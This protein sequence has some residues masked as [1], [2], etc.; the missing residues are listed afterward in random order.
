M[1]TDAVTIGTGAIAS[2]NTSFAHGNNTTASGSYSYAEGNRTTASG[3]ASH[4]E[5]FTTTASGNYS[6]AANNGTIAQNFSQTA[7]GMNNIASDPALNGTLQDDAFII[8]NSYDSA[9]RSNAFR[10]QFT[11]DVH[12]ASSVYSTGADYAE[13]F[14]WQ[15]GNTQN[16]D[17]IGYFVTLDEKY[18]RKATAVDQY[19]LGVVSAI[20]SMVGD[21]QS[22]GWQGMYLRDKW[23]RIIYEWA[24]VQQEIPETNPQTGEI[25]TR[26]ETIRVQRPKLNP[27]Y[28]AGRTYQ[29]RSERSEW[30]AVGVIGKLR[31]R[32]DGS[33]QPNGFC[34][35]NADGIAT[36]NRQGYRVLYRL[37][38]ETVLVFFK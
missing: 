25:Q 2:G 29:P 9:T 8:G 12:S 35:P 23:G 4:A 16:E 1:G 27:E 37:D 24:N 15:D 32:D 30:A 3:A 33:C 6:H 21:S 13:M 18:I 34:Q 36:S 22:C 7:I 11:G 28:D 31:V 14:E 10:V 26:I 17:R 20:P 38:A 19:I 5:G